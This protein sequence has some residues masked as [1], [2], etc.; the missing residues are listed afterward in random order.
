MS[1]ESFS[2]NLLKK[3]GIQWQLFKALDQT[4]KAN[5][6]L[7]VIQDLKANGKSL[8]RVKALV[9]SQWPK[10]PSEYQGVDAGLF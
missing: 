8:E 7:A 9:E 3:R 10:L 4:G 2:L 1:L 5:M 6:F